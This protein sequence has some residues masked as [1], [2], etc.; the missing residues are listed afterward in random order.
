[1]F[2]FSIRTVLNYIHCSTNSQR[3]KAHA[4]TQCTPTNR[5]VLPHRQCTVHGLRT[6]DSRSLPCDTRLPLQSI[7]AIRTDRRTDSTGQV[8]HNAHRSNQYLYSTPL[9]RH[10]LHTGCS[11]VHRQ[12]LEIRNYIRTYVH[13]LWWQRHY[14]RK[15]ILIPS[16][17]C[18]C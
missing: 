1:M 10:K 2:K 15:L 14:V 5:P 11:S 9:P 6:F 3:F 12:G 4:H 18:T 16:Y 7:P 13:T 8:E 17:V